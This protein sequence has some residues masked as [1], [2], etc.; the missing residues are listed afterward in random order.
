ME[1]T[2][3]VRAVIM[4]RIKGDPHMCIFSWLPCPWLIVYNFVPE[5]IACFIFTTFNSKKLHLFINMY[6]HAGC[7]CYQL[8]GQGHNTKINNKKLRNKDAKND[9]SIDVHNKQQMITFKSICNV[10]TIYNWLS[11]IKIW[12]LALS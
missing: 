10:T 11:I 7:S 9:T 6:Y 12:L 5:L 1:G 4:L 8:H 3:H 2:V